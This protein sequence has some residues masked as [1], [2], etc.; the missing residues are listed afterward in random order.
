MRGI[1]FIS[2]AVLPIIVSCVLGNQSNAGFNRSPQNCKPSW[3]M[4]EKGK[5]FFHL[6]QQGN[7]AAVSDLLS[8][9]PSFV[10]S[11]W[12]M[13]PAEEDVLL[14]CA[15]DLR[16]DD[17]VQILLENGADP[18][19]NTL[20][21]NMHRSPLV[22]ASERHN[23][24]AVEMLF[25]YGAQRLS[26]DTFRKALGDKK[27]AIETFSTKLG[28]KKIA[29]AATAVRSHPWPVLPYCCMCSLLAVS[30]CRC[31]S[32]TTLVRSLRLFSPPQG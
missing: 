19:A 21:A 30:P 32:S 7:A 15:I 3:T 9:Q 22:Q 29:T 10:S 18:D 24:N 12:P 20:P 17:V 28:V 16:F 14:D 27:Y 4:N 8:S 13:T 2:V 1:E 6:A 23:W 25:R 26:R 31:S 5:E 11:M